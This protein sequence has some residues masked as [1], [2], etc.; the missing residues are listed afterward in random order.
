MKKMLITQRRRINKDQVPQ[1]AIKHQVF[2][3]GK[4]I[5]RGRIIK[6]MLNSLI[7]H[8][9]F[10][11]E[12]I[13]MDLMDKGMTNEEIALTMKFTGDSISKILKKM[14]KKATVENK[15]ELLKWWRNQTNI[16]K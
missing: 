13:M 15:T 1:E 14:F 3:S 7:S 4:L 9:F 11:D 6:I 8:H 10:Q 5:L 2:N 12:V 16:I